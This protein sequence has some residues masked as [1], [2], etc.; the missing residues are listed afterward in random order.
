MMTPRECRAKA[1]EALVNAA[2][3]T[4]PTVR[5]NY[6]AHAREWTALS[7]IAEVQCKLETD[8]IERDDESDGENA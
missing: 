5:A 7:M 8:L 1:A 6:N 2:E 3:A 4:D